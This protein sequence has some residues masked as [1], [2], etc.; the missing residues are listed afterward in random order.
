MRPIAF[1]SPPSNAGPVLP[2]DG[3]IEWEEL[4]SL[5]ETLAQRLVILGVSR[6]GIAARTASAAGGSESAWDSTRPAAL[7]PNRLPEPFHEPFNGLAVREVR[8]PDVFRHFFGA[9]KDL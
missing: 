7:E 1:S 3:A 8:E 2:P 4:P 9:L 6:V 5:V